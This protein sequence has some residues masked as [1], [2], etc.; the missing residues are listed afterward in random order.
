MVA[1]IAPAPNTAV[2]RGRVG[3]CPIA[4]AG[5]PARVDSS[6]PERLNDLKEGIVNRPSSSHG[7]PGRP[8]AGARVSQTLRAAAIV[9]ASLAV[10]ALLAA[11]ERSQP[12]PK[13]I[14][15]TGAGGGTSA[16]TNA[17]T[18]ATPASVGAPNR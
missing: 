12:G 14:S 4:A 15:G 16:G 6:R 13:P 2:P 5:P 8:L 9:L 18:S 1:A 7:R 11:C 3:I 17:G 10:P